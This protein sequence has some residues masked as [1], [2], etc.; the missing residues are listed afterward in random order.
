MDIHEKLNEIKLSTITE[1]HKKISDQ[2]EEID[3][4][5]AQ[6]ERLKAAGDELF[7][8]IYDNPYLE[9]LWDKVS[10]ETPA[11]SL[12]E[13]DRNLLNLIHDEVIDD[14]ETLDDAREAIYKHSEMLTDQLIKKG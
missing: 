5:K 7:E 14:C 10:D 13:H 6:V 1:A 11:Q 9:K 12:A 3:R 8:Q 4:L 2:Q